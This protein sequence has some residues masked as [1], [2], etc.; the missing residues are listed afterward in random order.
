MTDYRYDFLDTGE[1]IYAND[2]SEAVEIYQDLYGERYSGYI[3]VINL[4]D[5]SMY[6]IHSRDLF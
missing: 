6:C 5:E 1:S 4:L 3:R 2:A